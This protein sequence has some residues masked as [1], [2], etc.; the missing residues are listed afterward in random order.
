MNEEK[1]VQEESDEEEIEKDPVINETSTIPSTGPFMPLY[2][3]SEVVAVIHPEIIE[4]NSSSNGSGIYDTVE[5]ES[6]IQSELQEPMKKPVEP[7]YAIPNKK[8]STDSV[9]P[10]SSDFE[11]QVDQPNIVEEKV[12]K[13]DPVEHLWFRAEAYEDLVNSD[14][15]ESS[16]NIELPKEDVIV[17][18]PPPDMII[19]SPN[20]QDRTSL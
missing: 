17:H 3:P 9:H 13:Q 2:P 19:S 20:L 10:S 16:V 14:A 7:I 6:E 4:C 1:V 5:L 8:K 15:E 11:I 18:A 12:N